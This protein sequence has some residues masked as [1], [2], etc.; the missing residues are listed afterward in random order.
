L[1]R[2]IVDLAKKHNVEYQRS[3]TDDL[4]GTITRLADD[5]VQMDGVGCLLIALE[6]AGVVESE[7]V[8]PLHVNSLRARFSV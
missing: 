6:R 4:A 7:S 3:P 5:D 8:V 1:E 2:F